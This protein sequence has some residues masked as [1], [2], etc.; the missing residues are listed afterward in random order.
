MRCVEAEGSTI[1]EAIGRALELLH[2]ERDKVDIEI[3]ENS[4]RGLLGFGGKPARVRATVRGRLVADV[5]L[6]EPSPVPRGTGAPSSAS[7]S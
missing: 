6:E 2:I 3:L 1:D 4:S 5:A 7:R